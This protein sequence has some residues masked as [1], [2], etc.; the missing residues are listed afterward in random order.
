MSGARPRGSCGRPSALRPSTHP[1]PPRS[2]GHR[3]RQRWECFGD[4][5]SW[6]RTGEDSLNP[7]GPGSGERSSPAIGCLFCETCFNGSAYLYPQ[8]IASRRRFP[9]VESTKSLTNVSRAPFA[10]PAQ[11]LSFAKN[12]R[13]AKVLVDGES[14]GP[15]LSQEARSLTRSPLEHGVLNK[16][17]TVV[18]PVYNGETRLRKSVHEI[19]ELAGELTS[20]F[21]VL[22]I[23]DGS[24]DST[25]EVAEELAA[26]Y[27][28]VSVRRNRH[29]C[30]LGPT[31]D[32]VQ[33][34]V[35]SDAVIMHDGASPIDA[36]EMRSLW[37]NWLHKTSP[38]KDRLAAGTN[39]EAMRELAKLPAIHAAIE[40]AHSRVIG[41]QFITP[42]ETAEPATG[43]LASA[44][45]TMRSDAAA[46]V[47]QRSLG[48]IPR[49]PRPKFLSALANFAMGE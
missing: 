18:L 30:G 23:D 35:R 16:S 22:I 34:R 46:P 14:D 10:L 19:L 4:R 1:V 28:Q 33:R 25:Y 40:K 26:R 6:S 39:H 44:L 8:C 43:D 3:G 49:L 21:G 31:I 48:K 36:G 29:R 24:N 45:Q 9:A 42:I 27:P 37:R 38:A 47:G 32:Y 2:L 17:L 12:F 7:C 5:R 11:R 20:K 15:M 13:P 41:F